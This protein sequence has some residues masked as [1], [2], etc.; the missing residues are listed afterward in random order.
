MAVQILDI[1]QIGL[2]SAR[3]GMPVIVQP[4]AQF[5]NMGRAKN[6]SRDLQGQRVMQLQQPGLLRRCQLNQVRAAIVLAR[7]EQGLAFGIEAQKLDTLQG[8]MGR[9]ELCFGLGKMNGLLGQFCKGGSKALSSLLGALSWGMAY[10]TPCTA[11][12]VPSPCGPAC[13]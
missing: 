2:Q 10:Y 11:C 3:Q 7:V 12:L 4:E 1:P 5:E 6:V 8:F 9:M 13:G